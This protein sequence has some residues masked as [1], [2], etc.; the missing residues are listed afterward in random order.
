MTDK[1]TLPLRPKTKRIQRTA[2]AEDIA[3]GNYEF[4]IGKHIKLVGCPYGVRLEL[5]GSTGQMVQFRVLSAGR[6]GEAMSIILSSAAWCAG[7]LKD[8]IRGEGGAY[9]VTLELSANKVH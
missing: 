4:E 6:A 8:E 1:L 7:Y 3:P 2:T 5:L 9:M